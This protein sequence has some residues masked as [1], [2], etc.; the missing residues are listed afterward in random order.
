MP[1]YIRIL[2]FTCLVWQ[3]PAQS[4]LVYT[5]QTVPDPKQTGTGYV[6]DPDN[7]LT[8]ADKSELNQRL[9]DIENATTAQI[10]VVML[11]SIGQENPKDFATRLFEHWGI[12]KADRD[13]GLLILSVM[14]QRRTE[15]ETGYGMEAVLPD[16][17]CYR[18][19]MQELVPHYREGR[20]GEGLLKTIDRI[21]K[22]L[23]DPESSPDITSSSGLPDRTIPN[24]QKRPAFLVWLLGITLFFHI[25]YAVLLWLR[26]RWVLHNK[27]DL[28]DKYQAMRP[29]NS[30]LFLFIA[31][32]FYLPAYYWIERL[33]HKLRN[34]P[35][36][37][38]VNGKA[39]RKLNEE[40][41]DRFLAQG[42]ITEE[43]IGSVDYDVWAT[44]DED[45]VLI[46][47]YAQQYSKYSE[48]PQCRY[49]TWY[50]A[51]TSVVRK[52]TYTSAGLREKLYLC[53]NCN[54]RKVD[55]QVIPKL[56]E[57]SGSVA[58]GGFSGRSGGAGRSGSSSWGGGRS[59]GGGAG[60]SW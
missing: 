49:R 20:Y 44:D 54:Y 60:V 7:F 14:D 37:S 21:G 6:S 32:V 18:I 4:G 24:E 5:I 13:N 47:R 30:F 22:I 50:L 36:F 23:L 39:M 1:A 16:A 10:A 34:Q 33:L 48:C 3:L 8:P 41:E 56:T 38:K 17:Y 28:Y 52:A 43:E 35:R 53:K 11:G 29:L 40:E 25:G 2:I 58:S 55:Q 59:G 12:G 19:G 45:D 27:D 46:L 9:A 42:Q 26:V 51:R 15:F 31:P 57:S